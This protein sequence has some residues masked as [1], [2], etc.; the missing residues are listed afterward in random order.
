MMPHRSGLLY[1]DHWSADQCEETQMWGKSFSWER[2]LNT[3][4]SSKKPREAPSQWSLKPPSV[5]DD[6]GAVPSTEETARDD[7]GSNVQALWA[8]AAFKATRPQRSWYSVTSN[9]PWKQQSHKFQC[10]QKWPWPT[11]L[12]RWNFTRIYTDKAGK[13][14]EDEFKFWTIPH[15]SQ[16][17]PFNFFLSL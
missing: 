4:Q 1:G 6:S 15:T 5:S 10:K 2:W 11:S 9:L 12:T 16:V 7:S 17:A 8:Q 14:Q 13:A 3:Q